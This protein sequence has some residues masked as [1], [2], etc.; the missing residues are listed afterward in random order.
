MTG[1]ER[2]ALKQADAAWLRME[3]VKDEDAPLFYKGFEAGVKAALAARE[4]PP[5]DLPRRAY[6]LGLSRGELEAAARE[7]TERPDGRAI[8]VAA[9]ARWEAARAHHR[10][11]GKEHPTWDEVGTGE[12]APYPKDLLLAWECVAVEA[13]LSVWGTEQ[14]PE[15]SVL[16]SDKEG[17]G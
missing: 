7:D 16:G 3:G 13:F 8:E 5:D 2:E 11:E 1:Q 12:W 14:E 9:K 4:E 17:D 15:R 6:E 10:A